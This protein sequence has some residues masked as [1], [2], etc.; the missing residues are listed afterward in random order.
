MCEILV[1]IS[2]IVTGIFI[3]IDCC[4]PIDTGLSES[5]FVKC[6]KCLTGLSLKNDPDLDEYRLFTI[7]WLF[8]PSSIIVFVWNVVEAGLIYED[9]PN[10]NAV[11]WGTY[12]IV[13][14]SL[15][16]MGSFIW[17]LIRRVICTNTDNFDIAE[18]RSRM[19]LY[20][21]FDMLVD[22][23]LLIAACSYT[24]VDPGLKSRFAIFIYSICDIILSFSQFVIIFISIWISRSVSV[25]P[26]N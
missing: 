19:M 12:V 8:L 15:S 7:R 4:R 23:T 24:P 11:F 10:D 13:S 2:D 17:F 25:N 9:K 3:L 1:L 16:A 20:H 21:I 14:F 5:C 18:H 26:N 6:M 22:L